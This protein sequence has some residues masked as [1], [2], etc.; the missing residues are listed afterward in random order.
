MFFYRYIYILII[1]SGCEALANINS[2]WGIK[3]I[4]LKGGENIM[5]N[6]SIIII[7][8]LVILGLATVMSGTVGAK[9]LY[10]IANINQSPTPIQA[11]DIQVDGTL[12]YQATH[13][14]PAWDSGAV[15]LAIDTDSEFLFVTYESSNRIQLVDATTMSDEGITIAPSASNL[16]GIVVD[17][18]NQKIYT[19]D[20]G[21]N[22]LYVYS[23]YANN[24]TL[25]LD[26]GTY[27]SLPGVS[28]AHGIALDEVN[29]LLYIGDLTTAVKIFNTADWSSAGSFTIS[30]SAMGIALDVTNGFVYT[31]NAYPGYGGIGLLSKYDLNTGNETTLDIRALTG[32]PNDNVVG[33]SV[34]SSTGILYITTGNQG[35][36]GSDKV[37]VFDLNL[38][39]IDNTGDI[40][41]PTGL[42]IPGKDISY[43]PL[44]LSKDDGL[45]EEGCVGPGGYINYTICFDNLNDYNVTNVILVDTLPEGVTYISSSDGSECCD[46]QVFWNY[47]Q[48]MSGEGDCVWLLVQVNSSVAPGT[49]ITNYVTI[50][51]D[52]TP[53]TTQSERTMVCDA[54]E[55]NDPPTTTKTIGVPQQ[56]GGYYITTDTSITFTAVDSGDNASG[57]KEIHIIIDG[58]ET[59]ISGDEFTF[60]FG[61]EC[62]HTIE[63][64]A[65]DNAGNIE[66]HTIQDHFVDI[67]G[68]EQ[69]V[70]FGNP[71]NETFYQIGD[72]WYT[73]ISGHTPIWINSTDIGCNGTGVG[74]DRL[75]YELFWGEVFGEW[76]FL[77]T[78]TVFDN[79]EN[80]VNPNDGEIS[81]L[82][83]M[84]ESC[85]HEIHY[86]CYD[87]LGNRAP[88]PAGSFLNIDFLVDA[89][90][91]TT[92]RYY[93]HIYGD[94]ISCNSSKIIS[95]IDTGCIP[96]GSGVERIE[97][98][99]DIHIGGGIWIPTKNGVVYDNDGNDSNPNIGEITIAVSP[100]EDCEHHIYDRAFDRFGNS[101]AEHKEYIKVDCTPPEIFKTVGE[102][103]YTIIPGQEYCITNE[104]PITFYAEDRGCLGGVGL[105]TVEYNIWY[106]G[107]W[108]GWIPLEELEG[109][110]LYLT[111]PCTHYLLI[112]AIDL[113]GNEIID[114]ETFNVD[115]EPPEILKTVGEP[116][117]PEEGEPDYWVSCDT[118]ITI[119]VFD[120]G[121]C[122]NL[123]RVAYSINGGNW[124][125][126]TNSL[127]YTF[128]FTEDC[129]HILSIVAED[130]IGRIIYDN[131]T[132]YV[133]CTPPEIIKTVGD[134][135]CTLIP[136]EEYCVTP[137]TPITF[138]A[139][140]RGCNGGVG[141]NI[142]EF[143][144][145]YNGSWSGWVPVEELNEE[146]LYFNEPCTHYLLIRA[147][148]LFGNE[149]VDNET[150]NVD[151]SPPEIVKTVGEPNFP[152][153]EEP[154]YWVSCDTPITIDAY[155]PGCCGNLTYVAY[156][157][158][159]GNFTEITDMLPYTF[160]FTEDCEH[161]LTIIA[162]DC[163]N[164][165]VEDIEL[166]YVD[167]TPP[168]I[169]KTIGDPN[170]PVIPGE[171]YCIT[172]ET[173]IDFY[174][175]DRGCHGGVGLNT[176]EYNI[177][178][179]GTWSGWMDAAE[180][181]GPLYLQG[182]CTHY[183]LIR[184]TDLFGNEI[185]DNETF[186]VDNSAPDIVKTV[187]EPYVIPECIEIPDLTQ[188]PPD[189]EL[190]VYANLTYG[191]VNY[192]DIVLSGVPDGYIVY[193]GLW[194][195]WCTDY[196]TS[197]EDTYVQLWNTYDANIPWPDEDKANWS[198]VN[199]IINHKHPSATRMDIQ[200]AIWHFID[201]T[202]SY[203][204]ADSETLFMINDALANGEDF[205]PVT[206][207]K[208]AVFLWPIFEDGQPRD[209]QSS[210]IEILLDCPDYWVSCETPI[211]IDVSYPGCCETLSYLG[212]S[213]NDG[214]WINI[215]DMI[216]YTFYFT[217][218]CVHTLDI[219]ALDF[220]GNV[221]Y[222]NETFFV[223]CTPPEIIK[224]VGEP[225]FTDDNLTWWVTTE[226]PINI[227]AI[228]HEE[229]C[230][231]GGVIIEYRIWT[232]GDWSEWIVYTGNFTFEEGCTHYLEIRAT[233]L[234]GNYAIDNETFIV[235]GPSGGIG[236][237][238]QIT[239]PEFGSTQSVRTLEVMIYAYDD[240][241]SW[242]DLDV[243]LWIPGGRR[244]AP[245]LWYEVM[246][247]EMEDY[248]VAYIDLFKYQDGAQI[249]LNAIAIDEDDYVEFA[250]PVT[251]TIKSTTIW[252]QWMQKGWNLMILPPEIGCNE[253]VERVMSSVNG[254]YDGVFHFDPETNWTGFS[255]FI[256]PIYNN[257]HSIE[258]GKLYWV[259]ITNE[260]GIRYYIGLPEVEILN[261]LDDSILPEL[262]EI[263]GT[264]WDSQS[265]IIGVNIWIYYKDNMSVKHYWN[266]NGSW[267]EEATYL[268][269]I[270]E[271]SYH[272]NWSYDSSGVD[273]ICEEEFFIRAFAMDEYGCA[274]IDQVSFI[275]E[276]IEECI[277]YKHYTTD[278]DFDEGILTSLE[279][280]TVNDQL[281]I[282]PGETSTYP[283]LWIANAGED[284][285]SKWDTNENKELARYHTWFGPLGSHDAW[286]GPAPSRTCVDSDGNCY[287]AN[288]HFD[289]YD[290]DVIKVYTDDW[291]DRNG[292]GVLDTS[293]DANG[294]GIIEESEM[295]PMTDS[296]SNGIIDPEEIVDERIA[297]ATHVDGNGYG[298]SLAIDLD[299]NIWLGCYEIGDYYKL[300]GVD[301]SILAGPI[302]VSP[303]TPYGSLVDKY[304]FLWGSGY[305]SNGVLRLN[306]SSYDVELYGYGTVYMYGMAIGYD[307][308]G[309]TLV[310][311]GGNSPFLIF[312]SS[313]EAFSSPIDSFD[314][315]LGVAVDSHGNI[316]VG[317]SSD[318]GIAKYAPDT[319]IIW[320]VPGQVNSEVRGI[321]VD[322]EDNIWAVHRDTSKLCKYDGTNGS[323]LGVYDAGRYP[324]TYSDA[325]G[326]GYAGSVSVG[327]WDVIFD[328]EADDTQFDIVSWTSYKPEGTSVEVTVRSS[329]DEMAWSPWETV[330][331]GN[332]LTS[333]PNGRYLQILTT[334]QMPTDGESPILYDLTVE[335]TCAYA[336]E[337]PSIDLEK[338][339]WDEELGNWADET[340]IM[341]NETALFNI[342]I[343][344]DG[345]CDLNN[346]YITD[347]LPEGLEYVDNSTV[348]TVISGEYYEQSSGPES[349]PQAI[350][351]NPDNTTTLEWWETGGEG[352]NLTPCTW[353]F[354]EFEA[355]VLNCVAP[356]GHI[357]TA[358]ITAD[359]L[360]DEAEVSDEGN[361]K[362]W[363]I[364][365][366][367]DTFDFGDAPDPTY[368]TL[369]ANDGAR[370]NYK[371]P[372]MG[373]G[374][375]SDPDGQPTI[376][377]DGDDTDEWDDEDG[378]EQIGQWFTGETGGIDISMT[379]T[380]FG[381]NL[382]AWVDFNQDGD[383]DDAGEQIFADMYLSNG[384]TH[385]LIVS[386]P[387]DALLG[388]TYARFR[389]STDSGLSYTGEAS[390]G[391]VEDHIVFIEEELLCEPDMDVVKLGR[392]IYD[393][394]WLKDIDVTNLYDLVE[395][396][397][398]IHNNA[399]CCNLTNISVYDYLE[400]GLTYNGYFMEV[401][402]EGALLTQDYHY[403]FEENGQE[404][405]WNFTQ[406]MEEVPYCHKIN[407]YFV[408]EVIDYG[409]W[410]NYVDVYADCDDAF[411]EDDDMAVVHLE[412]TIPEPEGEKTV[413]CPVGEEWNS[414]IY[415]VQLGDII[416]FN[417][418]VHNN[419][420]CDLTEIFVKDILPDNLQYIQTTKV[421]KP[422]TVSDPTFEQSG[423][424]LYWNFTGSL[425][426]SNYIYI[427]FEAEVVSVEG[428]DCIN[429]AVIS[430]RCQDTMLVADPFNYAYIYFAVPPE[431]TQM[432]IIPSSDTVNVG[433][434]FTATVYID[435][436]YYVG[437]WEITLL[438][439]PPGVVNASDVTI[440]SEWSE[441]SYDLGDIDNDN[442]S[443]TV[444]TAGDFLPNPEDYPG[445]NH[446]ACEINFIAMQQGTCTIEIASAEV[447]RADDMQPMPLNTHNATIT[448]I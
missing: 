104:T 211:T 216:P 330:T 361:A 267:V 14:V 315:S 218:D 2:G 54:G 110:P 238:I 273:W 133:D 123:S 317:S 91:P 12:I 200:N 106:A 251:F 180:L 190:M 138:Y 327:T 108:S 185:V 78:G 275:Y 201:I 47:T 210:F 148:D 399:T 305:S 229:P 322:S 1:T 121:C 282:M 157:I 412:C 92:T 401:Y 388:P 194:P 156:S 50:D 402:Y 263:N 186:N 9:S 181:E 143:N 277:S 95:A 245:D 96:G 303:H 307:S 39:Q 428:D 81:V 239:Y 140:D 197:H 268:L 184:A 359:S 139:E 240:E 366:E 127:P 285:L 111:E 293:Y 306:T 16:A 191:A 419:G 261:P 295:L 118:P 113:L 213:I 13:Y 270:L 60:Y 224:T 228:D 69:T 49:I 430:A 248:Y 25:T 26:G 55:D 324:Y 250:A 102:P 443:I 206:G 316:V 105:A 291:V 276:C 364:C 420:C 53:P 214:D 374:V 84:N 234:L 86:W 168:E 256:D 365:E 151:D 174:A 292:N 423:E 126:I 279:H 32:N 320:E 220:L 209:V 385:T 280:D 173:P 415:D 384:T 363:G 433:E 371:A 237:F 30:Q 212:Y 352:F 426:F 44:N 346:W 379:W 169:F 59:I 179:N 158:N 246:K 35:S 355:T 255:P 434:E 144:V 227:T 375:D 31:G 65:V 4:F 161:I 120:S 46:N 101:L 225:S 93:D 311:L 149:I 6:K 329:V 287:V 223:D 408:V 219:M 15:G 72:I 397:I 199:Y 354:I 367:P 286:S 24:K 394:E 439:F 226:T 36:G 341:V 349:Q 217:E 299:G 137:Q 386:I 76:S 182:N 335:A 41:D 389:I 429:Q 70:E 373:V 37:I 271:G 442:G 310:Y 441:G 343:H 358:N 281:Q 208:L 418:T 288:R 410:A 175:E 130:N 88:G 258:G 318:G 135:N 63:F 160:S 403:T 142:T 321:V 264:A 406:N 18:D 376:N 153:I 427:E 244:D 57:V 380:P 231:V 345:Y 114:N 269:C 171:E 40:G 393:Q 382:S 313:T 122:G 119:D 11:Y 422:G 407:I 112:R 249:T 42:T 77:E 409:D 338:Y 424:N 252:D 416:K 344:N 94:Y 254:S 188:F 278:A 125:E 348:I 253:S 221:Q 58:D 23:W 132:F 230:A 342:S 353:M 369:L 360:C 400:P 236:P 347:T 289:T 172:S 445:V 109:D 154:D 370:H 413:W 124:T 302:D 296:N 107:N 262:N 162:R 377:A 61:D 21:T 48:V 64:W 274:A 390:D 3:N 328:S 362:V 300:S 333:T 129:E 80:D 257:L 383:W 207:Q 404:L 159:D 145:W 43:N 165:T 417:I 71:K 99:V 183:L 421:E 134:P 233:D 19:V 205:I 260:S 177:W 170:S 265:D 259:H 73:G 339:V 189:G 28:E 141:V 308:I 10:V 152:G 167:C 396:N 82:L 378:V 75:V 22:H 136:N 448:I 196:T 350:T 301:G 90:A 336:P 89:D 283:T 266:G 17:H 66:N 414:S 45:G 387:G 298:R 314:S 166:F 337:I 29:D 198:Y 392:Y 440:G 340:E 398:T 147:V 187:G 68:P 155:E 131:E 357:N 411:V 232:Q 98:R 437:G 309:N 150:F 395:F 405:W 323:Y 203:N 391:E 247:D 97:W 290:P 87:L 204:G 103:S 67:T 62:I 163:L 444:I 222:D 312:N 56:D 128:S 332:P 356:G 436:S 351:M 235:H 192:F 117:I 331:N 241:T 438:S 27:L 326:I 202:Q 319:T 195:G 435:P 176:T 215:T 372:Y 425:P 52:E 51:S 146:P 272:Y 178:Y 34:D 164:Q 115:N 381:G 38:N 74:S 368:P 193:D 334:M 297:W 446:T 116:N 5:K 294:N 85:W 243:R 447:W 83:Y 8:T 79:D 304:G 100:D 431:T 7:C 33:L 20:R 325:T 432:G 242:D 284:S